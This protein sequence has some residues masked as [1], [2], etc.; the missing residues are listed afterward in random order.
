MLGTRKVPAVLVELLQRNIF[1][2]A[3]YNYVAILGPKSLN[4]H[5][6][7][8]TEPSRRFDCRRLQLPNLIRSTMPGPFGSEGGGPNPRFET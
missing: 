4:E 5:L 7:I 6:I 1:L 2:S 8:W 3:R